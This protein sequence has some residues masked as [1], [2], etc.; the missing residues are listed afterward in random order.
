MGASLAQSVEL[1]ALQTHESEQVWVQ[2]AELQASLFLVA[3]LGVLLSVAEVR[4]LPL[5]AV[6]Q[7][8][9]LTLVAELETLKAQAVTWKVLEVYQ[10]LEAFQDLLAELVVWMNFGVRV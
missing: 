6:E 2:T 9:L 10:V 4:V 8:V 3:G 1:G 5:L 7:R